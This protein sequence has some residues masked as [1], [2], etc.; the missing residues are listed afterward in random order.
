MWRLWQ[1]NNLHSITQ[2][3]IML[4]MQYYSENKV[5]IVALERLAKEFD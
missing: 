2:D 3:F 1:V 5:D 4:E